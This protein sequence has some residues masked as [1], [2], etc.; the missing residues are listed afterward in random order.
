MISF[1]ANNKIKGLLVLFFVINVCTMLALTSDLSMAAN[2]HDAALGQ[3]LSEVKIVKAPK[4]QQDKRKKKQNYT[5][6]LQTRSVSNTGSVQTGLL[7][8][9]SDNTVG[10]AVSS[11]H[12][13]TVAIGAADLSRIN[14]DE[15]KVQTTNTVGQSVSARGDETRFRMG[16][17]DASGLDT[18]RLNINTKSTIAGG[19]SVK[20]GQDVSIGVVEMGNAINTKRKSSKHST[21]NWPNNTEKMG[22]RDIDNYGA[23][24]DLT[25]ALIDQVSNDEATDDTN[26]MCQRICINDKNC[27]QPAENMQECHVIDGCSAVADT[28]R[29]NT[30]GEPNGPV[31]S[32]T[33]GYIPCNSHDQ[34]YQTC[35][36][37]KLACDMQLYY[38]M[39]N[40]CRKNNE[41]SQ[42]DTILSTS[43]L[44]QKGDIAKDGVSKIKDD[45]KDALKKGATKTATIIVVSAVE[46]G[47]VSVGPAVVAGGEEAL[48][49]FIKDAV[50]HSTFDPNYRYAGKEI[51]LGI[52]H[53]AE[54]LLTTGSNKLTNIREKSHE[55]ADQSINAINES[56]NIANKVIDNAGDKA[57]T[58]IYDIA[59]SIETMGDFSEEITGKYAQAIEPKSS[60]IDAIAVEQTNSCQLDSK[61][62]DYMRCKALHIREDI[63]S[64]IMNGSKSITSGL[65]WV[66]MKAESFFLHN[67]GKIA[68][69][70]SQFIA[71]DVRFWG[72]VGIGTVKKIAKVQVNMKKNVAVAYVLLT[73]TVID[74]WTSSIKSNLDLSAKGINIVRSLIYDCLSTAETYFVGVQVAG[75]E[76]FRGNNTPCSANKIVPEDD[77]CCV[78]NPSYR[79][80]VPELMDNQQNK[81]PSPYDKCHQ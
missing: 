79:Y 59:D 73:D 15:I 22:F 28:L 38:D 67:S 18:G 31:Y 81:Y 30:F 63:G 12:G 17:V 9:T 43:E 61:F 55:Y 25:E 6:T 77:K 39:V 70:A 46:T 13:A 72:A 64:D 24:V 56:S 29:G 37:D 27:C 36:T 21:T 60:F 4:Q 52:P 76:H 26:G 54:G 5:S 62:Y 50:L 11:Q 66:T 16:T 51:I 32:D 3:A 10:G 7:D 40:E 80:H 1:F 14:A 49:S 48:K 57:G 20:D 68:N 33:R 47:G 74:K 2:T 19:V 53:L 44:E 23:A 45:G 8:I 69:V 34:C 35:G 41:I 42:E 65:S 71:E 58:L 75:E 78:V